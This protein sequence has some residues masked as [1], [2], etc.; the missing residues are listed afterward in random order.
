MSEVI[1]SETIQFDLSPFGEGLPT[2]PLNVP[3]II[4]GMPASQFPR[5]D[6]EKNALDQ[7]L[8]QVQGGSVVSED[9]ANKLKQTEALI[10]QRENMIQDPVGTMLKDKAA[11]ARQPGAPGLGSAL[12]EF[13][14]ILP[15]GEPFEPEKISQGLGN[16]A[17]KTLVGS[18]PK[19]TFSD[20]AVIG[21]D[22]A[23]AG[24]QLGSSNVPNGNRNLAK[25]IFQLTKTN[26]VVGGSAIVGANIAAKGTGNITYDLINDATR[27]I[28]GLPDPDE[29]YKKDEQLRNLMDMRDEMLF[30]GGAMGLQ[31]VWPNVKR[32]M[33]KAIFGIGEAQKNII[34][35]AKEANIPMNVFSVSPSGM[36]QAAG[37]VIG[38]FPFVATKARQAQNIQQVAIA[39]N[40]NKTL[41]ALSPI[42]LFSDSSLA[43]TKAFKTAVKDF[44][45]TKTLLYKRALDLGD[46]IGE[47]FIPTKRIKEQAQLLESLVY[48]PQGKKGAKENLKMSVPGEY[49]ITTAAEN[50]R[51]FTGDAEAFQDSL[52][53]LQYLKDDFISAREF[54]QLQKLLNNMKKA[55]SKNAAIGTDMA[56][57]DGFT[58]TMI[59]TL[60]DFENFKNLDDKAKAGL[61]QE[62]GAAMQ[63][64]ND[65]FFQNKDTF[66]GR[67]KQILEMADKNIAKATDDVNPGFYTPDSLTKILLNDETMMAP[68]ALKEMKEAL[69]DDAVRAIARSFFDD[70]IR[71][72]TKY[73]SGDVKVI[74]D[75][76]G[77]GKKISS[78]IS[79]K[80]IVKGTKTAQYNIPILDVD[81]LRDVFGISNVNKKASMVEIFGEDQ[82]KKI[83]DV[84]DLADQI[85]QTSFGSVS[86]FVKRRG[87]LGGINAVTNL[88]FGGIVAADPFGNLG[89]ILMARYGMSK[90]ADPKFLDS[91]ASVMNPELGDLAKRQAL[92]KLGQMAFDD[93][94]DNKNI[95]SEIR[96]NYDPG[97]PMDVMK[98]LIFGTNQASSYPGNEQMVIGTDNNGFASEV[99]L[100]KASD[101]NEFSMDAQ[102]V[103]ENVNTETSQQEIIPDAPQANNQVDPFLNVDFNQVVQD[104][105]VGMGNQAAASLTD[106]QRIALAGGDLD[107]AIALGSDR[108][109]V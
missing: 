3:S 29:A 83:V 89:A 53:N 60:N 9:M 85:Q 37:K 70:K 2:I 86:E 41:N 23:F 64:A 58:N 26:P 91:V 76:V 59:E 106:D 12:G 68:L 34:A 82:Y 54:D 39:E 16:F 15:G 92:I 99:E 88:A 67:T 75:E 33:G 7:I 38:L 81:N 36:V 104:T 94:S 43:A 28:M 65:F 8:M 80:E 74:N 103:V 51:Q 108:G 35:K 40:I 62:F 52:I 93:V 22:M 31:A 44:T 45:G 107:E 5:N 95:P 50:L 73:I 102:G 42:S 30:S 101:K 87:F 63:L 71:G 48:G 21:S 19:S 32:L 4:D 79:G 72:A 27:I 90:L 66:K 56:G 97:N 96:D 10:T 20:V 105:G 17:A 14:D 18:D 98:I 1:G 78:L 84:L 13:K 69:G 55:A 6:K 49:N 24:Q 25:T 46:K 100:S 57:V 61:V 11:A 109:V 77:L 47:Q